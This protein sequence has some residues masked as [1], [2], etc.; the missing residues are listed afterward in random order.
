MNLDLK[1]VGIIAVSVNAVLGYEKKELFFL[2]NIISD[3]GC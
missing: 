2:L 3:G 1:S